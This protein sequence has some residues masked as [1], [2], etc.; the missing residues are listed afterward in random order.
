MSIEHRAREAIDTFTT[1][2]RHDLD[3]HLRSLAS[4]LLRVVQEAQDPWRAEL[5]RAVADAR[6]EAERVFRGRLESMRGELT[7]EMDLRLAAERADLQ[8]ARAALKGG[9]REGRVDTVERLLGAIR[10]IDEAT[11]LSG[12]LEALAKGAAAETSRVAILLVEGDMLHTW[13]H[14]GFGPNAGPTDMPIGQAGVLAAAVAL[15]QTAFVP[16]LLATQQPSTPAFMCVPVGQTGLVVPII[17]A[18]EVVAVLYADDVARL[19]EQE[20]APVWTEEVEVLVRH[21]S[22]RLENVTSVRTVEVL[23]KPV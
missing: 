22:I 12:I 9:V 18:S 5:E 19:P 3:A 16:P 20:D 2:V 14:F 4:D 1:R 10:R 8:A 15:R 6:T 21:A 11:S 7:R 13:G 23:S 17:V